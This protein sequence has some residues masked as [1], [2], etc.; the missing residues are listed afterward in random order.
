[1]ASSL[2]CEHPETRFPLADI[3]STGHSHSHLMRI[4]KA[5]GIT[6]VNLDVHGDC[7]AP[8]IGHLFAAAPGQRLVELVR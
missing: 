6:E 7:K 5:P 2:D 1:M 4:A 3:A 8:M